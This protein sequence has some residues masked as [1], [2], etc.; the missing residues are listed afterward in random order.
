MRKLLAVF[1]A[2]LMAFAAC[3]ACADGEILF[4]GIPWGTSYTEVLGVLPEGIEMMEPYGDHFLTPINSMMAHISDGEKNLWDDFGFFTKISD[5]SAVRTVRVAG[6]DASDLRLFFAY[7]EGPDGKLDTDPDRTESWTRI[8]TIAA[9]ITRIIN[10]PHPARTRTLCRQTLPR[11]C[12][13]C[14]VTRSIRTACI[15][16]WAKT[17]QS[18]P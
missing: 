5:Y 16:G 17:G 9:C 8:R 3:G 18:R 4:R 2:A 7:T 10:L 13:P 11:N 15:T 1:I 14:T 12:L 6:Y